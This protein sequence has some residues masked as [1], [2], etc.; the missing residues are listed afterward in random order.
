MN[1]PLY[2]KIQNELKLLI[3]SGIYQ[4]GDYLPSENELC[5]KYRITRTTARKALEELIKEGF[6]ER[7]HGKGSLV[8]ERRKSL[9]LLNVKGFSEAVGQNV[10]T[11]IIQKPA[12]RNWMETFPF[13]VSKAELNSPCLHFERIRSVGNEPVMVENNWFSSL[14][15]PGFTKHKFVSNSFFKTLS[16]IYYIEI[17]GSEQELRA[18]SADQKISELLKIG[19]GSPVLQ[20]FIHFAT[21]R[22]NLNIYAELICNT[23]KYSVENR[24]HI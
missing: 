18:I 2:K 15:L 17:I 24:Y 3:Q 16:Q 11:T 20:I 9:G 6:I 5:S 21:S 4:K 22:K 13:A 10:N 14:E 19:V 12:K 1:I 8:K 7:L 23:S